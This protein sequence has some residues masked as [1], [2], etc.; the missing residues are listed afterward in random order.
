MLD[1]TKELFKEKS[2]QKR[3]QIKLEIVVLKNMHSNISQL[4]KKQKVRRLRNK[5]HRWFIRYNYKYSKAY[6]LRNSADNLTVKY[7]KS[8]DSLKMQFL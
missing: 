4:T 3:D 6:E 8:A 5:I 1:L 7:K 2:S